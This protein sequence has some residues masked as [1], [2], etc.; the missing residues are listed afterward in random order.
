MWLLQHP[1]RIG[2]LV[3]ASPVGLHDWSD[4]VAAVSPLFRRFVRVS[5]SQCRIFMVDLE[6]QF[7]GP[8]LAL[9]RVLAVAC[10]VLKGRSESWEWTLP[11]HY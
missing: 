4:R 3:L 6:T 8:K 5:T 1:E 2:R 11:P 10:V 9:A 7:G